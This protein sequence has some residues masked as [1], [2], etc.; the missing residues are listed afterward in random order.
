M[1]CEIEADKSTESAKYGDA[2]FAWQQ[3]A[4]S[5]LQ[6]ALELLRVCEALLVGGSVDANTWQWLRTP[7]RSVE[8]V[9][10]GMMR[11]AAPFAHFCGY[12]LVFAAFAKFLGILMAAP[13][14][15]VSAWCIL[16]VVLAF[17]LAVFSL[18]STYVAD[19]IS[20]A[21]ITEGILQIRMR[22]PLSMN[23][24]NALQATIEG[25]HERTKA[26][27][28]SCQ[29]SLA[30]T[31]TL[32]TFL[33]A[34]YAGVTMRLLPGEKVLEE[35]FKSGIAITTFGFLTFII[36]VAVFGYKR[37]VDRVFILSKH[38]LSEIRLIVDTERNA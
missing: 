33:W 22:V 26:R 35:L 21:L 3:P 18:P 31:W 34:Q 6:D 1:D 17:L 19:G 2:R 32:G 29:W 27:I 16:G 11:F 7:L 14:S 38:V 28:A 15:D 30:A 12:S 25:M 10:Q 5:L 24:M 37:S 13:P 9:R 4:P 8:M 20:S 23:R 36:L